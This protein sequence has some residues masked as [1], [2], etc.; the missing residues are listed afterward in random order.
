MILLKWK[1]FF[2]FTFVNVEVIT[3][4]DHLIEIVTNRD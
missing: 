3:I 2:L 4:A 1:H